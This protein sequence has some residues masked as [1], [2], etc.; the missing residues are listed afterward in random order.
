MKQ[1]KIELIQEG[2]VGTLVLGA[3]GV[4]VKLLEECLNRNA[5]EGWEV[6][7]QVIETRRMALFWTRE[8]VVVTFARDVN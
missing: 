2:A 8:T 1:Y 5:K 4:P 3:S 7:F 6:V